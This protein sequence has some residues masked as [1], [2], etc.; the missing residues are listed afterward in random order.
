MT[1]MSKN[2]QDKD[3]QEVGHWGQAV[4]LSFRFLLVGAAAVAVGWLVSN[5]RQVPPD[6]QAVILRLGAVARIQGPGLLI[7]WPKPVEQV[8][9]VPAAAR[10][11]QF[12]IG[13]FTESQPPST[14][15]D[16][17]GYELNDT[18]RLN[19]GFLLSGDSSVVHLEARVFYQ[20][21]DAQSYMIAT[22]HIAPALQRIFI[23]SAVD[24]MAARDLDTILVAR[25]EIAS[26][27]REAMRREQLRAD[28]MNAV[29]RRLQNLDEQGAGL[30]IRLSRVDLVPSIPTGAKEAFDSVLVVTQESEAGI[31]N[32]RTAAEF[33]TQ[34]ANRSRDRI[35]TDATAKAEETV[36]T[37]KVATA[38]ITALAQNTQ[39][40]SHATLM[41]RLYYDRIGPIIKKAGH[42]KLVSPD[43][44]TR[45]VIPGASR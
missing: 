35:Q 1:D 18:P 4:A 12:T 23:A 25:P 44:S 27:G 10:Q 5:I 39:N 28:L 45:L 17:Y 24:A 6:S 22:D 3:M 13:R 37:A 41:S 9:L 34:A 15:T 26:R 14:S 43:G 2:A 40:M 11:I 33:M 8:I 38:S 31:A 42:L 30:G 32:A 36:S 21:T 29:N 7:A 16:I 19:S 20:I